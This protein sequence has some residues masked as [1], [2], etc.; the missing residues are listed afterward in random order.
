MPAGS[1]LTLPSFLEY[2]VSDSSQLMTT[3]LDIE[4]KTTAVISNLVSCPLTFEIRVNDPFL[5]E[6]AY[7]GATLSLA[8]SDLK[9]K[10]DI[11]GSEKIMIKAK[12]SNGNTLDT[13]E[14]EV[15]VECPAVQ[16]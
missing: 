1:L 14:F 8:G 12:Q 9:A 13:N 5:G 15:K 16:F 7:S 3:L 4:T 2:V 11:I 6:V 10:R